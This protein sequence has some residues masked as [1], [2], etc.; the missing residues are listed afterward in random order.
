M[1]GFVLIGAAIFLLFTLSAWL[2]VT[3]VAQS[4]AAYRASFTSQAKFSLESLFLFVDTKVILRITIVVAVLF[5]IIVGITLEQPVLAIVVASLLLALPNVSLRYLKSRRQDKFLLQLPD[6]LQMLAG[7]MKAGAT[8]QMAME[9]AVQELRPPVTQEFD[10]L[11][12]ELRV[13]V[14]LD[15]ALQNMALRM[16]SQ[17][18]IL[19]VT[20]MRVA[21]EVG[22]NLAE[23]LERL[24]DTLRQKAIMEGKIKALTAQGKL[25]GIVVGLLPIGLGFVLFQMEPESMQP[26]LH[27]KMGWMVIGVIAVLEF[28]GI[29]MIRKIVT[30]DI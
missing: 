18:M 2:T 4:V 22:G 1:N 24:A 20:A 16:P 5:G 8:L 12:R 19:V 3:A 23:I 6:A 30:I 28:L 14:T 7:S 13:G 25:Q 26:L 10:L 29:M 17:D 27:T 11:L 15:D 9:T 21:R